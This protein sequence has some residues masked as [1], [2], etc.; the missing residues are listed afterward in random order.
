[1]PSITPFAR[2]VYKIFHDLPSHIQHQI[3]HRFQNKE[4][5]TTTPYKIETAKNIP[6]P[7]ET[8]MA[9]IFDIVRKYGS[10][11]PSQE[12]I[13]RRHDYIVKNICEYIRHHHDSQ[14]SADSQRSAVDPVAMVD[15]GGGDG[16]VLHAIS[17][18]YRDTS[19]SFLCIE[20]D[21]D[22]AETYNFSYGPT[23]EYLFW[24]GCS[25]ESIQ[26]DSVDIILC[27]VSLHHMHDTTIHHALSEIRRILKVGGLL[28]IKEHDCN[29]EVTQKYIEWEHHLYHIR[30]ACSSN[31][32]IDVDRYLNSSI[33]NFKSR[34]E[35]HRLV[36]EITEFELLDWRDRFLK[37][38]P[39]Q[40]PANPT[41]LYWAI[42]TK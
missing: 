5:A 15:W 32:T 39:V 10:F 20:T 33:F 1:M 34:E 41:H 28:M 7:T 19:S 29:S 11:F 4:N 40:I 24:D 38:G 13:P 6:P 3:A 22:W 35:W 16:H 14:L 2:I 42:Y 23:V 27:M 18:V 21:T 9:W 12:Y 25:V 30:D 31:T 8:T 26:D 37:I 17:A 36:T